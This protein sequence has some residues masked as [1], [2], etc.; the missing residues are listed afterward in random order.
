MFGACR[1]QDEGLEKALRLAKGNRAELE[2]VLRHYQND[3]LKLEAAKFLIRYM[4][5]HYSYADTSIC[6]Y[7]NAV[8]STLRSMQGKPV[9]EIKDSLE[10]ITDKF[11]SIIQGDTV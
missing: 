8:D 10:L 3:S 4:P 11:A 5:G 7:Y 6:L 1:P 2:K 9:V